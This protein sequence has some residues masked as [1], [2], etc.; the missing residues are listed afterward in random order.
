R[1]SQRLRLCQLG[2]CLL[3]GFASPWAGC[4]A[5]PEDAPAAPS[6]RA[7]RVSQPPAESKATG[8]VRARTVYVPAYS[9]LPRGRYSRQRSPLSILL[10]VRNVDSTSPV[11]LTHVDYF[12]TKG[13]RVRRY[14]HAPETLSPLQTAEFGVDTLDEMGGSGANFL[15]HWRG[16]A[17]VHPLLCE[18]VMLGHLGAGYV[19]FASRGLELAR[20]PPPAPSGSKT[21]SPEAP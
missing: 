3:L 1:H 8:A 10:S 9:Y 2:S 12:D 16:P 6:K 17:D 15:V 21:K 5:E 11:T 13:Q 7:R 14:L 4:R 19:T 18:T 20:R